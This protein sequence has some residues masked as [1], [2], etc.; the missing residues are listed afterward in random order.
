MAEEEKDSNA[1]K[2]KGRSDPFFDK[3][4]QYVTGKISTFVAFLFFLIALGAIY[5]VVV[6]RAPLDFITTILVLAPAVVGLIAYSNRDLAIIIFS[7]FLLL[8]FFIFP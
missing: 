3:V 4:L 5:A 1:N 7:A 2:F 8:F 6:T